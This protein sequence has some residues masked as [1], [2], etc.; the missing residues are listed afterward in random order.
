M[1]LEAEARYYYNFYH[2]HENV[3]FDAFLSALSGSL[4]QDFSGLNITLDWI[5]AADRRG[6]V[7]RARR[8][9]EMLRGSV[10]SDRNLGAGFWECLWKLSEVL[11]K[12]FNLSCTD[13]GTS[14]KELGSLSRRYLLQEGANRIATLRTLMER[15]ALNAARTTFLI[16]DD[17]LAGRPVS[18]DTFK[19]AQKGGYSLNG[20]Y[21]Q[22]RAT[23]AGNPID[24]NLVDWSNAEHRHCERLFFPDGRSMDSRIADSGF[25]PT[26]I[27]ISLTTVNVPLPA[28]TAPKEPEP[29]AVTPGKFGRTEEKYDLAAFWH[30]LIET[31]QR[32]LP[33]PPQPAPFPA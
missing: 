25:D 24:P 33:A 9:V 7:D 29:L 4:S 8:T 2:S 18:F 22:Y 21:R 17:M 15:G 26:A 10:R 16:V 32:Q 13:I 27:A 19:T 3:S 23:A 28:A 14:E 11:L 1:P 6:M 12:N 20:A 30:E 5:R 31:I